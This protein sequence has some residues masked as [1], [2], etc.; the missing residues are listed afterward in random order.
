V[1]VVELLAGLVVH[2]PS[3]LHLVAHD[4]VQDHLL[5]GDEV[6]IPQAG[7][8][9]VGQDINDLAQELRQDDGVENGVLF[10]RPGVVVGPDSGEVLVD[11][12]GVPPRR[13]FEDHVLQEVGHPG[14]LRSFVPR[15]GSH[16]E[17]NS[18]RQRRRVC[19]PQDRQPVGQSLLMEL[20][21]TPSEMGRTAI[22]AV[23]IA[24]IA[25]IA[26]LFHI[27]PLAVLVKS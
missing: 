8:E 16:P 18:H 5:F 14:H 25:N 13:A 1:A 19:F 20:H 7:P 3:W 10:R 27:P 12:N 15:P 26:N 22:L 23:K 17:R 6:L 24:K 2:C 11:C 9:D 4:L 21:A